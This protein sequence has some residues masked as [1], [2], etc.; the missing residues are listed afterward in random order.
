MTISE[1]EDE[2]Y[3]Y[4]FAE[5]NASLTTFL[6]KQRTEYELLSVRK[7]IRVICELNHYDNNI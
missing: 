4:C 2:D 5:F 7:M 1:E 6:Y 3:F